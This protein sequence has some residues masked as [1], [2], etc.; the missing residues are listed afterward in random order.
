MASPL[1]PGTKNAVERRRLEKCCK[2]PLVRCRRGGQGRGRLLRQS[3]EKSLKFSRRAQPVWPRGSCLR[4][5]RRLQSR[6]GTRARL[7]FQLLPLGPPGE[8][9]EALLAQGVA[10]EPAFARPWKPAPWEGR[11]EDASFLQRGRGFSR[12]S[13]LHTSFLREALLPEGWL[14]RN[15]GV[16]VEGREAGEG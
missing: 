4:A 3:L 12:L 14:R 15:Q 5:P 2:Y 7:G 6:C 11:R 13:R 8:Q 9:R 16:A 1:T 10:R